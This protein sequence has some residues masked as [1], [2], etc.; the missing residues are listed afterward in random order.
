MCARAQKSG[1]EEPLRA[2]HPTPGLQH[3]VSGGLGRRCHGGP[4]VGRIYDSGLQLVIFDTVLGGRA[5]EAQSRLQLCFA[6][7][8]IGPSLLLWLFCSCDEQGLLVGCG[9]QA[10]HC[11]GFSC[12]GAWAPGLMG[13]SSCGTRA[14]LLLGMWN[15]PRPGMEP[16]SPALA[17][18]F[19]TTEPPG[20]PPHPVFISQP[21]VFFTSVY[22]QP[23][24][25]I[26]G[27]YTSTRHMLSAPR[28]VEKTCE[29][30]CDG[31]Q[32]STDFC[33]IDFMR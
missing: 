30:P 19:F 32:L 23:H 13:F 20:K 10:S 8:C 6:L 31:V 22:S 24:F 16:V 25:R 11:S 12:C 14:W 28:P 18:G 7:S 29:I 2:L 1:Q 15:L 33:S 3:G 5:A 21:S 9:A 17:D 4:G 26:S 27:R